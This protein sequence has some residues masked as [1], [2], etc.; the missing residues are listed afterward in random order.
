MGWHSRVTLTC[1]K[2]A[3]VWDSGPCVAM[4]A[5]IRGSCSIWS[6]KGG[7]RLH[8]LRPG[9]GDTRRSRGDTP[10]VIGG[11]G[12]ELWVPQPGGKWILTTSE[13]WGRPIAHSRSPQGCELSP[14]LSQ[15]GSLA[16]AEHI[17]EQGGRAGAPVIT[18]DRT[19]IDEVTAGR[20]ALSFQLDPHVVIWG[21]RGQGM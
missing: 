6:G 1:Q 14:A 8:A 4:Y 7:V 20:V 2:S 12:R 15:S 10:G 19:G 17:T 3:I 16:W 13:Q 21:N 5:G 18:Y 11:L 9:V